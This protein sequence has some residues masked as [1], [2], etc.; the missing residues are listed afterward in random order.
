MQV[1]KNLLAIASA[2]ALGNTGVDQKCGYSD[3]G[4]QAGKGQGINI[5]HL[6]TFYSVTDIHDDEY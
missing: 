4:E 1:S 3:D 2:A 5:K 6:S